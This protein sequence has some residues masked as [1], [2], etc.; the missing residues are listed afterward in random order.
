MRIRRLQVLSIVVGASV[1]VGGGVKQSAADENSGTR[2][3]AAISG[4][5]PPHQGFALSAVVPTDEACTALGLNLASELGISVH[6]I[7]SKLATGEMTVVAECGFT[8]SPDGD[9]VGS[10]HREMLMMTQDTSYLVCV[11]PSA[12]RY[13]ATRIA[14]K[15]EDLRPTKHDS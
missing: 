9:T 12:A 2:R 11:R 6:V 4:I 13:P 14:P 7:C 1:L 5:K 3:I 15:T 10:F 8:E